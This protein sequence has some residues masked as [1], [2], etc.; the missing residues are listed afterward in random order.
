M[1]K[2]PDVCFNWLAQKNS[3]I[4]IMPKI[5]YGAQCALNKVLT[6]IFPKTTQMM[7]FLL[8]KLPSESQIQ[9]SFDLFDLSTH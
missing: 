6:S 4:G 9:F 1:H 2:I 8:V 3:N 7:H 5:N